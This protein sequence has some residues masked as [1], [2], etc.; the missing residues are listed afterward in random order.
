M[1][2]LAIFLLI[3]ALLIAVLAAGCISEDDNS[4]PTPI[5][6]VTFTD[7]I[8]PQ[9]TV[10]ST[11][12]GPTATATPTAIPTPR[13]SLSAPDIVIKVEPSVV[14]IL[15]EWTD[16]NIFG[17]KVK[18]SAAGTGVIFQADGY[19][20]TNNH[21][22]EQA[23]TITVVLDDNEQYPATVV[24][25]D[26]LTDLAVI[27][28]NPK[29]SLTPATFGDS[30]VLR[31]GDYLL[32]IGNSLNL[33]G[34]PTVTDGIVSNLG[35]SIK[36]ESGVVLNDLIQTDAAINPGNSGGPLV[37]VYGEVVGINTAIASQ[38]ENIGFAISSATATPIRDSLVAHG[39]VIYPFMG[40]SLDTLTPAK[41]SELEL[42]IT[43]GVLIIEVSEGYPAQKAGLQVN[44]VIITFDGK[45]VTITN[46]VTKLL[47]QHKVGDTVEV[48]FVRGSDTKTVQITLAERPS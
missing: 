25:R 39:R 45:P 36:S 15:T 6:T 43:T 9:P 16:R 13:I 19:I 30:D 7:T 3:S 5:T 42:T 44:D 40:V 34:G 27:K 37:N 1:R 22:I 23:D 18:S 31:K 12:T 46:Q 14:T 41:A 4:T 21:V 38:A 29:N 17:Q 8:V 47:R 11:M 20:L 2:K 26:P 32:A 35:R 28:I 24:G 48:T 10:T 33:P